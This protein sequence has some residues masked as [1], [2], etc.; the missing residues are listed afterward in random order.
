M[1]DGQWMINNYLSLWISLYFFI[2]LYHAV[3]SPLT[4]K[5]HYSRF[6]IKFIIKIITRACLVLRSWNK[7]H[8]ILH[9]IAFKSI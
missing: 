7:D 3:V 6:V 1:D 2:F 5:G 9:E 4:P 8:S